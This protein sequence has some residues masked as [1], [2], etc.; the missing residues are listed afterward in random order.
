[1]KLKICLFTL[2]CLQAKLIGSDNQAAGTLNVNSNV[3]FWGEH[4]STQAELAEAGK[5]KK[6][7]FPV[8]TGTPLVSPKLAEIQTPLKKNIPQA[9]VNQTISDQ[10]AQSSSL[11][12]AG[13]DPSAFSEE[14]PKSGVS[15]T[16]EAQRAK[17][18]LQK[19]EIEKLI[20]ASKSQKRN[21]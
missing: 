7:Q 8:F 20:E 15:Q 13:F 9:F 16:L 17:A 11:V 10:N 14:G 1:M 12:T 19:T 18:K 2:V 4:R 21:N 5:Y 6:S 3:N